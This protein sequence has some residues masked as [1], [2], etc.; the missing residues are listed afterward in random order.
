[1]GAAGGA[2][3]FVATFLYA[4]A[5]TGGEIFLAYIILLAVI[6]TSGL[7]IKNT[8][9]VEN[10]GKFLFGQ[11]YCAG[12]FSL[13][14]FISF[15]ILGSYNHFPVLMLF[16]FIWLNDTG[17]YLIGSWIGKHR[18]FPRISP[19]KSWE[20]FWG[21][22]GVTVVI[23]AL[24]FT[25]LG[26]H[27]RSDAIQ[28][29]IDCFVPR[30]DGTISGNDGA[31]SGNDWAISSNDWAITCYTKLILWIVFAVITVVAATFGDLFESLIKRT[32]NAKDSGKMLPGHGGM[33]DRFD[34][35]LFVAP[36]VYL[37]FEIL[38]LFN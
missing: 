5:Y 9:Q 38:K 12:G 34:S 7:Y 27:E 25:Y 26:H 20:G 29:F 3:L 13:L 31:I 16:I 15:N 10:T 14:N 36:A 24:I 6:L 2:Y 22:L 1:M 19:K 37:F 21:G 18:L 11:L 17:A 30:N 33:L 4:G 23:A 35:A 8:N 32:Y 28:G